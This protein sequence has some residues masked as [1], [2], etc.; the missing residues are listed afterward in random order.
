MKKKLK[1]LTFVILSVVFYSSYGQSSK[2]IVNSSVNLNVG[3]GVINDSIRNLRED[4][5]TYKATLK[6][7]YDSKI[8]AVNQENDGRY[9]VLG[10]CASLVLTLLLAV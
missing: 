10:F 2:N 1:I 3:V 6:A 5:E 7:E 8:D 9:Q 4:F